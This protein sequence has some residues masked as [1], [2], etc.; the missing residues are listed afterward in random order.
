MRRNES[1][2]PNVNRNHLD[3]KADEM[4][5][6]ERKKNRNDFRMSVTCYPST[7]ILLISQRIFHF[8]SLSFIQISLHTH[9]YRERYC[10]RVCVVQSCVSFNILLSYRIVNKI[11]LITSL[12]F[13]PSWC[14]RV[15]HTR[16]KQQRHQQQ[17]LA[18]GIG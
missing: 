9:I 17:G 8:I 14:V 5:V 16:L 13:D 11:R 15:K 4:R 3:Q 18:L 6:N 7:L 1:N 2:E 12:H 10:V